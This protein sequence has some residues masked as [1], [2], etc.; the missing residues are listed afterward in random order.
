M[1]GQDVDHPG[2]K[3]AVRNHADAALAGAPREL[4]LLQHDL[5]VAAQVAEVR[6]GVHGRHRHPQ[7]EVVGKGAHGGGDAPHGLA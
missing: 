2:C 6:A 7:V 1:L 4:L 3:A 5:G